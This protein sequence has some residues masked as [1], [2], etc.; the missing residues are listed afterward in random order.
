MVSNLTKKQEITLLASE[1]D[2]AWSQALR[3]IFQPRGVNL[4]TAKNAGEFVEVIEKNPINATIVDM[5]SGDGFV[6]VRII[7]KVDP[8]VPCIM[9]SSRSEGNALSEAVAMGIF[10]VIDK[11]VDMCILQE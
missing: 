4:V 5:D 2:W 7:R 6:V 9:L 3:D 1:T 11:P 8:A 10:S